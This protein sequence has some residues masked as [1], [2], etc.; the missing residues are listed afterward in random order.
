MMMMKI[1]FIQ[2]YS[3][4]LSRFTALKDR[5]S[6]CRKK[7]TFCCLLFFLPHHKNSFKSHTHTHTHTH[8]HATCTHTHTQSTHTHTQHTHTHGVHAH[9]HT[10]TH[11]PHT[12]H[13]YTKALSPTPVSKS[14]S[15][16]IQQKRFSDDPWSFVRH[17]IKT[18]DSRQQTFA[19]FSWRRSWSC[20][21]KALISACFLASSS[22]FCFCIWNTAKKTTWREGVNEWQLKTNR[23]VQTVFPSVLEYRV[24]SIISSLSFCQLA[25]LLLLLLVAF[26]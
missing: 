15:R 18:A 22:A 3:L 4:L 26:I 11:T 24:R 19:L 6:A 12:T 1:A 17:T 25:L 7:R 8:T 16:I 2:R 13:R 23:R 14:A 5:R 10:H 9:T 20:F 21:C